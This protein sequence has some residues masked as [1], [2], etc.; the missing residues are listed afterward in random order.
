MLFAQDHQAVRAHQLFKQGRRLRNGHDWPNSLLDGLLLSGEQG[1]GS[2]LLEQQTAP[3]G[4]F[5]LDKTPDSL[6][7][8]GQDTVGCRVAV[9][10]QAAQETKRAEV[11][12]LCLGLDRLMGPIGKFEDTLHPFTSQ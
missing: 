8:K 9:I 3:D 2:A 12:S 10:R 11:I 4:L 1:L 5:C 6:Q 7:R